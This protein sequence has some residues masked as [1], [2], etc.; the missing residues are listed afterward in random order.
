V[1]AGLGFHGSDPR[2]ATIS[3]NA[4]GSMPIDGLELEKRAAPLPRAEVGVRSVAIPG[5][6]TTLSV[7]MRRLASELV[8]VGDAGTTDVGR[9]SRRWGVELPTWEGTMCRGRWR[10]CAPGAPLRAG[11]AV[12]S[13]YC[14]VIVPCSDVSVLALWSW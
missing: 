9:P 4:A 8:F 3:R 2:G 6:Q 1:K 11:T 14:T 10:P 7:W 12:E 5:L 13:A